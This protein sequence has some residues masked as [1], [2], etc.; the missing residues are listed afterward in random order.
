MKIKNV[1]IFLIL[2]SPIFQTVRSQD[3]M[4]VV[5]KSNEISKFAI[6]DIDSIVF[7]DPSVS[8]SNYETGTVADIDSNNYKTVKIGDQWWMAENL[9]VTRYSDSTLIPY[10]TDNATWTNLPEDYEGKA[11]CYFNNNED[12]EKKYGALYTLRAATNGVPSG[13]QIQG[14]CPTGW[15]LPTNDEW[16]Q[17]KDYLIANGYNW[18]GSAS[19]NKCAKSLASQNEWIYS[20]TEGAIGN[21]NAPNN[22]SGFNALPSGYRDAY[23]RG[24]EFYPETIGGQA[25]FWSWDPKNGLSLPNDIVRLYNTLQKIEITDGYGIDG[26]SVRCIKD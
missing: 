13:N 1:V 15:H 3:T 4:Y 8:N 12:G 14:V 16:I 22:T 24:G 9:K 17:L 6:S 5:L 19:G 20:S 25:R 7:Y 23:D 26:L 2:L 21:T 11:Y 18:D 10:V